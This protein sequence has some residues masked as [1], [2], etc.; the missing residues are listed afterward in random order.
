MIVLLGA[1]MFENL[2]ERERSNSSDYL[3]KPERTMVSIL[4]QVSAQA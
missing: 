4:R 2:V 1:Q 3:S